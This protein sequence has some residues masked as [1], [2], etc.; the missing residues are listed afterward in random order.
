[1]R[2]KNLYRDILKV[3]TSN[4]IYL[5]C[6][7]ANGFLIPLML[8]TTEYGFFRMF[9]LFTSY[10]SFLHFG[11]VDGI[12]LKY[13]G[14]RFDELNLNEMRKDT[15]I[16]T[17]IEGIIAIVI[18]SLSALFSNPLN[19]ILFFLG[20]YTFLDNMFSYF[21]NL[22]QAVFKFS[23][24][25]I[26][27][28]IQS[29]LNIFLLIFF[30]IAWR[31]Q[32]FNVNNFIFFALMMITIY[33]V[34]LSIYFYSY[35]LIIFK[36]MTDFF[37]NW[38]AFFS[39]LKKGMFLTLSYQMSVLMFNIDSQIVASFFSANT[40]GKYSFSYSILSTGLT[41]ISSVSIVLFP[42]LKKMSI[43]EALTNFETN[44]S[45]VIALIALSI[46][47]YFF[48]SPVIY[49]FMPK[50]TSS[51]VY[52]RY[53]LPGLIP[54]C[55]INLVISNYYNSFNL[56]KK[57]FYINIFSLFISVCIY[58]ITFYIFRSSIYLAMASSFSSVMWMMIT[59]YF[60]N[61]K[62]KVKWIKNF[63]FMLTVSTIFIYCSQF[64]DIKGMII[65]LIIITICI[66]AFCKKEILRAIRYLIGKNSK[67]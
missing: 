57:Y 35:R 60:F 67:I 48:V 55:C 14:N 1:M 59:L 28:I 65:Y 17:V 21:Q 38:R 64:D 40:F 42:Y 3:S 66:F 16:Y 12:L 53:L 34:L 24:L 25:S 45:C 37:I 10:T 62:Y 5:T 41:I 9:I 11:F 18:M 32:I 58:S 50:Y 6:G 56:V 4:F 8:S 7:V 46:T 63:I 52:L 13:A 54:I 23:E 43:Q 2:V 51:L 29:L 49:Q 27:K 39:L 22:S 61:R 20:I 30:L 15:R 31:F 26:I 47:A 44:I 33:I 19:I 36:K